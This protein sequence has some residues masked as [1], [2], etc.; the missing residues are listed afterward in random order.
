[1]SVAIFGGAGAA[2]KPSVGEKLAQQLFVRARQQADADAENNRRQQAP[3]ERIDA[4]DVEGR[5][6]VEPLLAPAGNPLQLVTNPAGGIGLL[7]PLG[8][9]LAELD[10]RREALMVFVDGLLRAAVDPAE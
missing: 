5:E 8:G 9:L 4:A 3:D 6:R 2:V 7:E 10:D 1:M